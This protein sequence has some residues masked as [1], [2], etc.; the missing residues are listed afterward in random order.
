MPKLKRN[1]VGRRREE[2]VMLSFQVIMVGSIYP[3]HLAL[4]QGYD[5]LIWTDSTEHRYIEEAGTM[6]LMFATKKKLLRRHVLTQ[7]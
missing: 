1:I 3:R 5:E 2:R 7:S 4:Q 6:N